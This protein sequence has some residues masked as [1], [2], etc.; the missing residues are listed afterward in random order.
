M[1]WTLAL[2]VSIVT[3]SVLS[4]VLLYLRKLNDRLRKSVLRF[5]NIIDKFD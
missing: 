3:I 1:D 5:E 2:G 4:A